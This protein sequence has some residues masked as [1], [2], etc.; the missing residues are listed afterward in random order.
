MKAVVLT[1]H[2]H[3]ISGGEYATNDHVALASDLETIHGMG[4]RIVPLREIVRRLGEREAGQELLVGLSFDDGPVFD[5]EDFVHPAFGPQRGF[6]NILRDF[7]ARHGASAQPSLHATSFVIASPE[8]RAALER[9]EEC[10]Y[11]FLERWLREDWWSAAVASGLMEIGNHSWDHVHHAVPAIAIASPVRDDFTQVAS[12]DDADREIRRAADFIRARVGRCELFAYPSG[13]A[14]PY[15]E[16]D[17]LP[18]RAGE[19]RHTA[20]FGTGG[21]RVTEG[22]SRWNIP[23]CVCGEHWRSPAQLQALLA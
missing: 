9:A 14:S 15:L 2:A 4:A 1:Y 22:T 12:Y 18:L 11:P 3:N 13:H 6:L 7:R 17:Y 8:A 21:G 5:F 20:A 10:G 19:H 16:R 23:R